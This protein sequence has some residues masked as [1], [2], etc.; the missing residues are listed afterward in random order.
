MSF[1]SKLL[2]TNEN[3]S[4]GTTGVPAGDAGVGGT[5]G[6]SGTL[7]ATTATSKSESLAPVVKGLE[8]CRRFDEEKL[9]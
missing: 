1:H 4:E 3:G 7:P 5:G 9:R 6:A 2:L 8:S